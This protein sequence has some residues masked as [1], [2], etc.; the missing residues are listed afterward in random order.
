MVGASIDDNSWLLIMIDDVL[1]LT[2]DVDSWWF[3]EAT[4]DAFRDDPRW[5]NEKN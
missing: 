3:D 4:I 2:V 1:Q 5:V